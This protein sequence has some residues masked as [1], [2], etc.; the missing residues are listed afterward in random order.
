MGLCTTAPATGIKGRGEGMLA[1]R[2]TLGRCRDS[3]DPG[4]HQVSLHMLPA[5]RGPCDGV[6]GGRVVGRD[7]RRLRFPQ[8]RKQAPLWLYGL[9]VAFMGRDQWLKAWAGS[10]KPSSWAGIL[11]KLGPLGLTY[12]EFS[13]RLC[14]SG[15]TQLI[16]LLNATCRDTQLRESLLAY[17]AAAEDRCPTLILGVGPE[18]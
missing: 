9:C 10:R 12:K 8:Q 2:M 6:L 7:Q 18:L 1:T 11:I 17:A 14:L 13:T 16:I 4:S 3:R 15:P 5:E